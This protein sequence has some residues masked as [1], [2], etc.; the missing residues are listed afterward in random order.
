MRSALKLK[1][2]GGVSLAAVAASLLLAGVP[3]H[4]A[5][6]NVETVVVTGIRG[7][8]SS[9][10]DTKR[11]AGQVLDAISAED[12]GKF[13][14]KDIGE[15]LARVTG[16]Q[17]TRNFGS[18]GEGATVT[19][20]GGDPSLTRVEIDGT[21][22][23]SVSPGGGD[24]S[25]DFRDLP[26][27]FVQRLE[28]VKS[29]TAD[30]VE[31]GLGGTV[32]V[33]SRRPFDNP[34]GFV[35]GS[36][37]I[38]NGDLPQS[39][40]P[41]FA[42]IGSKLFFNDTVGVLVSGE[43]A[44]EH[45]YD[46]Q[47]LTTGWLKQAITNN[48]QGAPANPCGS[49]FGG[50]TPACGTGNTST[51]PATGD[52]Y[53]QIPR[54]FNNRRFTVRKALN[55]AI[56]FRPND[57]F[58]FFWDLTYAEGK[59]NLQNQA[60][61][62]N[63]NGGVFDYANT[64]LGSD[65]TVNHIEETSNGAL[66]GANCTF[67]ATTNPNGNKNA[68]C[69]PLDLT[70]RDILGYAVRRI[71]TTAIGASYNVTNDVTVD[72]RGD[73]SHAKFDNEETDST[74]MVFG[75][76]RSAVDYTGSEHA[77]DIQLPGLDPTTSQGVNK[78]DA[79]YHP[80]ITNSSEIAESANVQYKPAALEWLTLKAG[81]YRHDNKVTN[82]NWQKTATLTCRGDT[83]GNGSATV[84]TNLGNGNCGVIT[85]ILNTTAAPNSVPFF[86]VGNLGFTNEIRS[87]LDQNQKTV[88]AVEQATGVNIYDLSTVNPNP[89][90]NGSF[91]QFTGNWTVTE[92][93]SDWYGE[94]EFSF[95]NFFRPVSGNI[96]FRQVITG[97][98]STGYAKATSGSVVTF[99]LNTLHG[100]YHQG[101][102]SANLKVEII[103]DELIARFAYGKVMARPNPS[104]L[105]I[106]QTLDIVG[107][108]GSSGNPALLPFLS[109]DYDAG[110]EWYYSKVD[111]LSIG[112]FQKNISRFIINQTQLVNV[113]GVNYN[114]TVPTNG[115][116]PVRINGIEANLNY[117][118]DWLP[119]PF[120]GLGI[121]YN[122]TSQ[123]DAGFKGVS[124]IDG[125]ALPFQG[126][127][128]MSYNGS[129]YYEKEDFSTRLSYVWRSRF[130]GAASGRGGL[131]EFTDAFGEFDASVS[132]NVTPAI[133]VF[134]DGQN[135][136]DTQ[137][138]I[139]NAPARPIEFDSFGRRLFFGVRAKY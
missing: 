23:L 8:L 136:L 128:R 4:A 66:N 118:F 138:T 122:L 83:V 127:S 62:L 133:S 37:Q 28:V 116:S 40:D 39:N 38:V 63:D 108:T 29:P 42:L 105:S 5:D 10:A 123:K 53:P 32:R 16:V 43:Y 21:T 6:P 121:V 3:A 71:Y 7:S 45:L 101:L 78:I 52:W 51:T 89:Q 55:S 1:L 41:K 70:Y 90:T 79:L 81:Y 31:G 67:N 54:Y 22:A 35:A 18:G 103:P 91:E 112:F 17:I 100:G 88:V 47:A 58:K 9:A 27:E 44:Q 59:E 86:S 129:I 84:L 14:D 19:I 72:L 57:D 46:D 76:P 68:G 69:L 73:Y 95:P 13:P 36:A 115:T 65:F 20:R 125:S 77:P 49:F 120:D 24:R 117:A 114:L 113:N 64:T 85:N 106:S 80:V 30:M 131:P 60:I 104:Q 82:T 92:G 25:V 109:T 119:A 48:G 75:V 56:E 61:Q 135:L 137:A 107:L 134:A 93:T 12:I 15:A 97:T 111:F 132:Y 33:I 74:A 102:P 11:N 139:E 99:P 50:A 94:A 126:L 34:D 110:L 124:L 96:G 98:A 130:L 26:V 87:W 2:N